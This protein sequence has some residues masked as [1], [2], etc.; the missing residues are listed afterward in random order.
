M[1]DK[2]K[3]I[4]TSSGFV[5]KSFHQLTSDGVIYE[6]DFM[7]VSDL[8][9]FAPGQIP[10]YEDSNFIFT[11]RKHTN[12]QYNVVNGSWVKSG[13]DEFWTSQNLGVVD[14][15]TNNAGYIK[16]YFTSLTDFA[17]FGSAVELIRSTINSVIKKFP[18][19]IYITNKKLDG[20]ITGYDNQGKPVYGLANYYLVKN[21]FNINIS[22]K[23][24]GSVENPY[25]YMCLTSND[26]CIGNDSVSANWSIVETDTKKCPKNTDPI[27]HVKFNHINVYHYIVD[28]VDVL[29]A[30]NG[31]NTVIRPKKSVMDEFFNGLD[32][33]SK[34]LL[35]KDSNPL[36]KSSFDTYFED[37]NGRLRMI[38][39]DYIWPISVDKYNIEISDGRFKEYVHDLFDL[40]S[41][42][43]EIWSDNYYRMMAH[44]SVKNLDWT[45][46]RFTADEQIDNDDIDFSRMQMYMRIYGRQLDEIKRYIDGI[47]F[48]NNATY[49][50]ENNPSD[51]LLSDMLE[52]SGW[53]VK[54]IFSKDNGDRTGSLY[55]GENTGYTITDANAEFMR[56]LKLN[57]SYI[58]SQKGTKKG[59]ISLL[60][61][62]GMKE[63]EDFAI[64]QKIY[65]GNPLNADI[66]AINE[67]KTSFDITFQSEYGELSGIPVREINGQY[68]PWYDANKNYDVP[69]YFEMAGGWDGK[70]DGVSV[71]DINGENINI[72]STQYVETQKHVRYVNDIDELLSL[73]NSSLKNE[74]FVYVFNIE[75]DTVNIE[76]SSHYFYIHNVKYS[77]KIDNEWVEN[78]DINNL[79]GW[80]SIPLDENKGIGLNELGKRVL[81]LLSL[82]E[83]TVGNNPHYGNKQY[84]GGASWIEKFNHIFR[85]SIEKLGAF[86][87]VEEYNEE[88]LDN[89]GFNMNSTTVTE[90][91]SNCTNGKENESLYTLNTKQFDIVFKPSDAFDKD[92]IEEYVL[93]YLKQMIPATSIFRVS[94]DSN[95]RT[96]YGITV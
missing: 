61:I 78:D 74:D 85:G 18:A 47:G 93:F 33:F 83:D 66:K 5:R 29:C 69:M 43:D 17:Y 24:V 46:S 88:T 51:Y 31:S 27:F 82:K 15:T 23:Q 79:K 22:S 63:D 36:Y 25:R 19:G 73:P 7:T 72:N 35:N 2:K 12:G 16:P 75:H 96:L 70:T 65:K 8:P 91:I 94:Y 37:K 4:K 42:Y 1:A 41:F 56:R 58:F 9:T 71:K 32:D 6:H 45:F 28:G 92:F 60:S 49:N 68:V 40:A 55:G 54:N 48:V 57:S 90:K 67:A 44:E 21:P 64:S 3:Y 14:D 52:L 87:G 86:V 59:L 11:V 50:Q 89:I 80:Y 20:L 53:E 26:F 39:K 62:F 77:H 10:I 38:K 81:Y 76:T 13:E 34:V 30:D 95:L 84:D